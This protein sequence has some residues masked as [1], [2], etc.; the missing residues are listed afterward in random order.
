MT[1]SENFMRTNDSNQRGQGSSS[2]VATSV[3][4]LLGVGVALL[5]INPFATADDEALIMTPPG[6]TRPGEPKTAAGANAARL[7]I[8]V[9]DRATD[10]LTPCRVNVVG[11][12]GEF[13]QPAYNPLSPYSLAGRWPETGK[14]NRQ[15]KGPFRYF[16]RFFYSTGETEVPVPPGRLR[17]EVWKGFEYRPLVRNEMDAAKPVDVAV[18]LERTTPMSALGYHLVTRISTSRARPKRRSSDPRLARS[19]G[20]PVRLDPGLQRT[21]WPVCGRRWRPWPHRSSAEWEIPRFTPRRYLDRLGAGISQHDLWPPE[22]L[23]AQFAGFEEKEGRCQQLATLWRRWAAKR[24]RKAGLPFMPTADIRKSIYADFVRKLWTP[25][26][27]FS[28]ASIVESSWRAGITFSISAIGFR[29]SEPAIIPL[30]ANWAI[31]GPMFSKDQA[32]L[33][34][35]AEAAAEGRS[36]VTSGP[37]L[38]LEVDGSGRA[39]SFAQQRG[40]ARM[41]YRSA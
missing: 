29:A 17:V 10:R 4:T 21:A 34:R 39:E 31:A 13:Y 16:G 20:Y 35:L 6:F 8:T 25:S 33:R 28:S 18:K 22:L 32:E 38:L 14:G 19:R 11:P 41:A 27:C 30:A 23:L 2:R 24:R 37:L 3:F 9:V 40:R 1:L 36:F 15:G 12:D 7:K 5:M 26:S